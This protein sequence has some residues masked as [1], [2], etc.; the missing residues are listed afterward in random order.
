[1]KSGKRLKRII[2]CLGI[3]LVI[4]FC[5][6]FIADYTV[7]KLMD[8]FTS[9][10]EETWRV[11]DTLQEDPLPLKDLDESV[12]SHD[13]QSVVESEKDSPEQQ[14]GVTQE[15]DKVKEKEKVQEK[16]QDKVND[17]GVEVN[18]SSQPTGTVSDQ[19]V[20]HVQESLTAGDKAN[21]ISIMA[22]NL[23]RSS[24][25]KLWELAKGG[26]TV[27]EKREAKELL[28]TTLSSDDYNK[29]SKMAKKYGISKG[30]TYDEAK[31][32]L[33]LQP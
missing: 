18:N 17:K 2:W 11:T 6:L 12:A 1:M 20:N 24:S 22:S 30:K 26:L 7:L 28:L 4:G 29:L 27:A 15:N 33:N 8:V 23:D 16:D 32:E 14:T 9:E 31:R 25:E 13:K 3:V 21:I 10:T 5:G 19:Q